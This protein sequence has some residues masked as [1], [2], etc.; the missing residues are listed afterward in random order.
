MIELLNV[1]KSYSGGTKKAVDNLSLTIRPGEVFGFLGPNGAGKTTTIKMIVGLL[2]PDSGTVR[3]GGYDV[4]RQPLEA[5]RQL[6][7]VPDTPEVYDK[8]TGLEYLNFIADVYGISPRER[9]ERIAQFADAFDLTHALLDRVDSYSHGMQ[10]KLVLISALMRDPPVWV[11]DEP[12]VGLD[13]RSS[14]QLKELMAEHARRNRTLFFSTHVLEVAERLCD[15]VAIINKGRI[16]A[17][18][19]LDELRSGQTGETLESIFLELT[20]K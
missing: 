11:L 17:C 8:L 5:K 3:V 14:Y 6:A 1:S 7:Y 15:R 10:Q 12:M 4:V 20:E 9:Q 13:P 2:R 16:I 18:G 19:T